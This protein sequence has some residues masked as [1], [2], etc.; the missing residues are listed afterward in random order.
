[1]QRAAVPD[2]Y[3]CPFCPN[4]I[5][6]VFFESRLVGQPICE[7]CSIELDAFA[8][9]PDRRDDDL[10]DAVEAHTGK[11]WAVCRIALL[12]EQLKT[13]R[14]VSRSQPTEW[15]QQAMRATGQTEAQLWAW[16]ASR[17]RALEDLLAAA[18]AAS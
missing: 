4:H 17:V 14:Q 6:D 10:I 7:G 13:W 5:D 16:V 3:S 2:G 12:R 1:M 8:E 11:P 15:V 18:G 9:E